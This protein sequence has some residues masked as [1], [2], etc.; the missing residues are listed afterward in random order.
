MSKVKTLGIDLA[1]NVFQLCGLD[2]S[3]AVVYR[4]RVRRSK[5]VETVLSVGA[6][7]VG[8]EACGG[9]HH[10]GRRLEAEGCRVRLLSP[11]R[12]K[13]FVPGGKN[14]AKDAEGIAVATSQANVPSVAV[15]TLEQQ[16]I[17]ALHRVRELHKRQRT[18]VVN[19]ARSLLA[20]YGVVLAR[21]VAAFRR[22]VPEV[23]EDA[24]NGLTDRIRSLVADLLARFKELDAQVK[25][26]KQEME[27]LSRALE[28]CRRLEALEGYGGQTATA[29]YAYIGQAEAFHSGR[30]VSASVGLVPSQ[31]SSGEQYRL[32]RIT[33]RGDRYLRT[34]LI[35]GARSM[36]QRADRLQGRR[37]EWLRG[38]IARQGPN[39]AAVALA[40]KN[41]R[42][43]WALLASGREYEPM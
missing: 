40:N 42:I 7:V 13:P 43:A 28:P 3:G 17:Q 21:G 19:Q 27:A 14:D 25:A 32:G 23:L 5:L 24:E 39:K 22:R 16:D 18:A 33:K 36:V 20:E 2:S 11:K 29:V 12:V 37:G 15:K 41:L 26:Y 34:L 1:K 38:V 8:M 35:H 31:H 6:E 30:Q 9:A 10:W 4:R